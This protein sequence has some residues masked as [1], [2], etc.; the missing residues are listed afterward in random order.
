MTKL[1]PS[2]PAMNKEMSF[3]CS[4]MHDQSVRYFYIPRG[5]SKKDSMIGFLVRI[6]STGKV[7]KQKH[8]EIKYLKINFL[9]KSRHNK[10]KGK[11][12]KCIKLK[13]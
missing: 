7:N 1:A 6:S 10:I 8:R 11:K 4:R 2:P 5:C 3:V 9:G 13:L 12:I